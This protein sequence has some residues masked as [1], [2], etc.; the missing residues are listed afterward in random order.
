LEKSTKETS[1]AVNYASFSHYFCRFQ[2]LIFDPISWHSDHCKF[3]RVM[4]V[5]FTI[6]TV[7]VLEFEI[8]LKV[9]LMIVVQ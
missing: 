9:T 7:S 3:T 6:G 8:V 2:A 5:G 1:G 4:T